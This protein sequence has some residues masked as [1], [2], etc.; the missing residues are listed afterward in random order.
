MVGEMHSHNNDGID[1][2]LINSSK[3]LMISSVIEN[4]QASKL[5][6]SSLDQ[7]LSQ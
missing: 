5:G 3:K 4:S 6:S 7:L 2:W 1:G